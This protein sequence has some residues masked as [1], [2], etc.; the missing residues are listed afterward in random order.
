MKI[1]QVV[2]SVCESK[3]W[4]RGNTAKY[5]SPK[6]RKAGHYYGKS[7]NSRYK[8]VQRS[9]YSNIERRGYC[10]DSHYR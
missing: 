6:C 8:K 2:C 3:F 1:K 7:V 9:F 5:C 10:K 4:A